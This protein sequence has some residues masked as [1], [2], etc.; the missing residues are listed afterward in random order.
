MNY[1]C[2]LGAYHAYKHCNCISLLLF[3]LW[4]PSWET[5]VHRLSQSQV[6]FTNTATNYTS[7]NAEC[8]TVVCWDLWQDY[9]CIIICFLKCIAT[10]LALDTGTH[11]C[12]LY[13]LG[14]T[15]IHRPNK[16]NTEDISDEFFLLVFCCVCWLCVSC[17]QAPP[18]IM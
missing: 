18:F 2:K 11:M 4:T 6:L 13:H 10:S 8:D 9:V 17:H 15:L 1:L 3:N 5:V 14:I 7:A 16:F 12:R